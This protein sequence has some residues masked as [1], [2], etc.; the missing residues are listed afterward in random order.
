MMA[1]PTVPRERMWV[2]ES[3]LFQRV[4]TN[5]LNC[6]SNDLWARAAAELP[7]DDRRHI[8]FSQPDKLNV[9]AELHAE[10][11]R[12]KQ[13]SIDSRWKYTRRSGETVIIRD[14]FEKI[15]RWIDVFK[16]VGD[17]VVQYDPMHAALPWAGIRFVLQVI[18]LH[19]TI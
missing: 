2:F 16:Q 17:V 7:D 12:S 15:V 8:N 4:F 3:A 6:S 18:L 14:V 10:A 19:D 9:L 5:S 13:K 11:E 1:P